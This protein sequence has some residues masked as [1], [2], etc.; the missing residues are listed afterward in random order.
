MKLL[1]YYGINA[2]PAPA[3]DGATIA[4]IGERPSLLLVDD[5]RDN[6]MLLRGYLRD[7]PYRIDEAY[8]GAEAVAMARRKAYDVIIMDLLMPEMD[9]F[10]AMRRIREWEDDHGNEPACIMIALTA[11]ALKEAAQESFRCGADV[12]LTKPVRKAQLLGVIDTQFT[13]IA[14]QRKPHAPMACT[15]VPSRASTQNPLRRILEESTDSS[16]GLLM[17]EK[18]R[19]GFQAFTSDGGEEFGAV[20]G[21][22]PQELTVYV[23]NAGDFSIPM[24][25]VEAVHSEKVIVNCKKLDQRLRKAIGHAHDREEPGA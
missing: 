6:L 17:Q 4:T 13:R 23:E 19:I 3:G 10:E 1:D 5:A 14:A 16:G 12:H 7:T 20:R 8:D 2:S 9:G 11:W 21:I 18:I 24:S 15:I 22:G 25:A